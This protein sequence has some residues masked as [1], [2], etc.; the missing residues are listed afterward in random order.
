MV[1]HGVRVA[2]WDNADPLADVFLMQFGQFAAKEAI[3]IDYRDSM[4]RAV[5]SV[6]VPITN[7]API[8][9]ELMQHPG[10]SYLSSYDLAPHYSAQA[11]WDYPG[12]YLGSAANVDDLATFWNLR[13]CGI[14]M[15][16][17]DL[18]HHARFDLVKAEFEARLRTRLAGRENFRN[19]PA[20]WCLAANHENA[21]AIIGDGEW[22]IVGV[23]ESTWNGHNVSP[24]KMHFGTES[25]LAVLGG[26][27][28]LPRL[29]F[30]L[31]D[32]PFASDPWFYEQHLVASISVIGARGDGSNYTFTPP[33]VPELNEFAARAMTLGYDNL[34]LEPEHVGII[35]N[36]ASVDLRLGAIPVPAL[37]ERTFALAGFEAKLSASGLVTRQLVTSMGGLD[38]VRAFKIPGVRRLI[39]SFGPT[40]SFSKKD[41]LNKI[42]SKDAGGSTFS[43]YRQ[44]YIEPRGPDTELTPSMVFTHLVHN[45]LFRIGSDLR[46]PTCQLSSWIPLDNLKQKATCSLCGTDF[47]AT[48]QLVDGQFAYRRSGVLGVERN[49]AGAIPVAMVLQQLF[50]NLSSMSLTES[51]GAS[52]D[53]R[54]IDPTGELPVCETDFVALLREPRSSKPAIVIG[55]CK[56]VGGAIDAN[57]IE[58]LRQVADAFP[59]ERFAVY[60]LLA[61]LC[62]FTPDEIEL[63]K[64]LNTEFLRRVILLTHKELEPYHFYERHRG[65]NGKELYASSADDL[66]D[67]THRLYFQQP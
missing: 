63:A 44:L 43:D 33:C 19:K 28:Q 13:A 50:I 4:D 61:K 55:E 31:K 45:G 1:E 6:N 2:T 27:K 25:A 18:Q 42:G 48:R 54:P 12:F 65:D 29:T 59:R 3:G 23:S 41:A 58:H 7:G 10:I 35:I 11:G 66:A 51:Y 60:I 56:D 49:A 22:T 5:Q 17:H 15:A 26:P 37:I 62:A 9:A 20:V 40:H 52:Y 38:G 32:K 53:L 46:C 67:A 16:W 47:D 8:P 14:Q 30:A 34:R 36:V 57:D 64:S 24:A 21:S 39:K